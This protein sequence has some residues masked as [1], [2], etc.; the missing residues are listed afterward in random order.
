MTAVLYLEVVG[1][2]CVR[3]HLC[4]CVCV[5]VCVQEMEHANPQWPRGT[6]DGGGEECLDGD[7][8]TVGRLKALR[9]AIQDRDAALEAQV[10]P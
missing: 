7:T 1:K 2:A 6:E 4:V 5:C 8:P 9:E 3:A 10:R